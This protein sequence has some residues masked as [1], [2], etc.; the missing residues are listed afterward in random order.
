MVDSKLV[1]LSDDCVMMAA[2]AYRVK[3]RITGP[4]GKVIEIW[5]RIET[6]GVHKKNRGGVY[7]SGVRCKSV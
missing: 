4:G 3:Y 7:P 6:T 2:M 1:E 5:V